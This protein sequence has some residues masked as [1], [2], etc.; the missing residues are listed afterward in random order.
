M[1]SSAEGLVACAAATLVHRGMA[2]SGDHI[3]VLGSTSAGIADFVTV[4]K[5]RNLRA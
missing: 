4:H 1:P 2:S 5:M 3:V